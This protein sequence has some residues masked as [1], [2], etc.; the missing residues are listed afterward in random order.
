V[1]TAAGV[2]KRLVLVPVAACHNRKVLD[3]SQH[4]QALILRQLLTVDTPQIVVDIGAHDG[5]TGSNSRALVEQ[6]WRAV[7]VEPLPAVVEQLRN[8]CRAFPQATVWQGACS[9]RSGTA[10]IRVGRDG[11]A[12]QLSSL[13]ESPLVAPH[14]GQASI[15]VR[16]ITL[17]EIFGAERIPPDFGVLLVDTEGLDLQ[18]LRGLARTAAR[19]RI[20]VTEDFV[21]T[22]QGKY[23]LLDGLGYQF[24]GAWGADSIW[25]FR[26]HR[27]GI[28]GLRLPITRLPSTWQPSGVQIG[29]QA[30][31]ESLTR[32]CVV[33]WA[34]CSPDETPPDE[35]VIDL[36]RAGSRQ[37]Y[38]FQAHRVPRADVAQGFHRPALLFSGFRACVDLPAGDYELR[39]IQQ[40]ESAYS[41]IPAGVITAP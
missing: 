35:V 19:P 8:N 13:S 24:L 21:E 16:T 38:V 34:I 31:F 23:A 4:G 32:Q 14:L 26:T 15:Q 27:V 36:L 28:E 10:T 40:G 5:I 12:G 29:G 37:R 17:D 11:E 39:I 22:N 25:I 33:G 3:Y 18:V 1:T 41:A 9:D 2:G 30:F 20:I 6:G 7:L